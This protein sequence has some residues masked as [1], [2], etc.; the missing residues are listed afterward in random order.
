MPALAAFMG[1]DSAPVRTEMVAVAPVVTVPVVEPLPFEGDLDAAL[2]QARREDKPLLIFFG[3]EWCSYCRQL[4]GDVFARAE[5]R[6]ASKHFLCVKVD[7]DRAR[8]ACDA[9]RVRIYP[10]LVLAAPDGTAIERLA[11]Y[12]PAEAIVTRMNVAVGAV[13]ASR[14]D[15]KTP[16]VR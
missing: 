3:T 14:T 6:E 9:Y 8:E 1:C 7:A 2:E 5:F 16:V 4:E 12:L 11:G 13:V 15:L 10:T